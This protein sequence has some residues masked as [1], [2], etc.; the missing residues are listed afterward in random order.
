MANE[1]WDMLA[2]GH[3][4]VAVVARGKRV[5]RVCYACTPEDAAAAVARFHPAAR[6]VASP[7]TRLTLE[8]LTEYFRGRRREFDV[9]LDKGNLSDFARKVQQVLVQVPYGAVVTYGELAAR[10]GSPRA[11]RAVGRVMSSNPFPLLVP[12][13]RVVNADGSLGRY[14]AAY[15]AD[16]KAWLI[17]FERSM[18]NKTEHEI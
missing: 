1:Q 13:H 10:V 14:S 4:V 8:Q 18:N 12:C 15:G 17:D 3:G 5:C 2:L 11:A 6:Q 16:S 9:P 7:C